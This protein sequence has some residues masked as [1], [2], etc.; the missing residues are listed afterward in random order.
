MR[1][2][3]LL[4]LLTLLL[5]TTGVLYVVLPQARSERKYTDATPEVVFSSTGP[6]IN[7]YSSEVS[8]TLRLMVFADTHLWMSDER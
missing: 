6:N 2:I 4:L 5:L 8:D 3:T 1:R 7:I